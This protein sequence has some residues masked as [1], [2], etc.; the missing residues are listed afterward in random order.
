M[1]IGSDQ[2]YSVLLS[3]PR[4]RSDAGC[5]WPYLAAL[6][7]AD[8]VQ[9]RHQVVKEHVLRI[10]ARGVVMGVDVMTVD[11]HQLALREAGLMRQCP[12]GIEDA[13][14]SQRR[15]ER[16]HRDPDIVAVCRLEPEHP[17]RGI[18]VSV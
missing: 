17:L 5:G 16:V 2:E 18:R 14:P 7:P 9:E 11:Q 4:P 6:G 8:P 15:A 3:A 13:P 12:R 10:G 1:T